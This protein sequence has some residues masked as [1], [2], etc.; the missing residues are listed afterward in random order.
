MHDYDKTKKK[1]Q[2]LLFSC[3]THASLYLFV[4]SSCCVPLFVLRPKI[5]ID[6]GNCI[7]DQ[8]NKNKIKRTRDG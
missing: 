7:F 3:K 6:W 4:A 5:G 1:E 8:E 2:R